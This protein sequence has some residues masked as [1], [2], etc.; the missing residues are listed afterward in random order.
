VFLYGFY[1]LKVKGLKGE[2]NIK[3]TK[4]EK[5][6]SLQWLKMKKKLIKQKKHKLKWTKNEQTIFKNQN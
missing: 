1:K 5:N 3:E 4:F 2:K 6:T